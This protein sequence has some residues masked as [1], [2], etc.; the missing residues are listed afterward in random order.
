MLWIVQRKEKNTADEG[1][2]KVYELHSLLHSEPS[3]AL[4]RIH[5]CADRGQRLI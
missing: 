5:V 2:S 1:E 3:L 4:V